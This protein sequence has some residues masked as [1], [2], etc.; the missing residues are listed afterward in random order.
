MADAAQKSPAAMNE[1]EQIEA[2]HVWAWMGLDDALTPVE[3]GI[4]GI[5]QG[6]TPAG[7][8][9]LVSIR[10]GQMAR[11]YLR[12]QMEHFARTTGKRRF[13]VR[14]RF[15]AIEEIVE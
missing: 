12:T 1:R 3:P 7:N 14:F 15:E 4:V 8:I 11:A 10:P 9:P 6:S 2:A 5:K 13:L